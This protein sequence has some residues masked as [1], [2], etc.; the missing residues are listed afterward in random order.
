[1][2]QDKYYNIEGEKERY[3]IQ[4]RL[5]TKASGVQLPE[6]HGMRKGLD[7]HK[8]LEKQPQP[9]VRPI[10]EKKPRLGQGRA[11]IKRKARLAPPSQKKKL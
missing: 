9:I 2:L 11:G 8:I 6:V 10:I 3:M 5:Q 7:P 1:M 4:T